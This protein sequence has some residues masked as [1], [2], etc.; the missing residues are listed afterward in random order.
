MMIYIDIYI[1]IYSSFGYIVYNI[2]G[3]LSKGKKQRKLFL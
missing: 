1:Y 3:F 2:F